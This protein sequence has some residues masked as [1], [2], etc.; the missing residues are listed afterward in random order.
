MDVENESF[1]SMGSFEVR[2]AIVVM[3][4]FSNRGHK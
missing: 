1:L 2:V 3:F 4:E